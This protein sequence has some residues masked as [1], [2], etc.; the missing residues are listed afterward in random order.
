VGRSE[1]ARKIAANVILPKSA[2][3]I[4][5][6]AE[7]FQRV[8]LNVESQHPADVAFHAGE[9]APFRL[10]GLDSPAE[11]ADCTVP[12]RSVG[13]RLVPPAALVQGDAPD[14]PDGDHE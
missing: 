12:V 9:I 3:F 8:V 6:P 10:E 13:R 2:R 5:L 1:A 7:E 14:E 4:A 11:P